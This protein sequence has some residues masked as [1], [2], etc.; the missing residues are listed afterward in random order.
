MGEGATDAQ[1]EEIGD[2]T[3][4]RDKSLDAKEKGWMMD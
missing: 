2:M 3:R 4:R 1:A